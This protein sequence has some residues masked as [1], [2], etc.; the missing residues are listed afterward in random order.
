MRNMATCKILIINN[1]DKYNR[2]P[3]L[4]KIVPKLINEIYFLNIIHEIDPKDYT[5]YGLKIKIL[6]S[7][8]Y[9]IFQGRV[10][11]L[12]FSFQTEVSYTFLVRNKSNKNIK[13]MCRSKYVFKY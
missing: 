7:K 11:V 6:K 2:I 4:T 3:S 8:S 5:T 1:F 13:M 12:S 10:I 9:H